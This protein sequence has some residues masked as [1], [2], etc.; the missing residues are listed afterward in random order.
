MPSKISTRLP[1]IF[2]CFKW[3][4]NVQ[5]PATCDCKY[6]I[7]KLQ[8]F[9]KHRLEVEGQDGE[10]SLYEC[11]SQ[12]EFDHLQ[13]A[14]LQRSI[15]AALVGCLPCLESSLSH[16]GSCHCFNVQSDR[17]TREGFHKDL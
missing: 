3:D 13:A 9:N 17:F 2:F 5:A 1:C 14:F 7:C 16:F 15:V 12:K 8:Q 6:Y 4:C 10:Y 11:C